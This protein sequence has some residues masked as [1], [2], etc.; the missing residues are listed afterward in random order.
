V[1]A[2]VLGVGSPLFVSRLLRASVRQ[3]E[4]CAFLFALSPAGHNI[5]TIEAAGGPEGNPGR[6]FPL[7]IASPAAFY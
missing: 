2:H 7:L 1:K 4:T 5:L 6:Q 3:D